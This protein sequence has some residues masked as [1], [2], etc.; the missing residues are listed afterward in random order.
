[1]GLHMHTICLTVTFSSSIDNTYTYYLW[2]K[3]CLGR[4]RSEIGRFHLYAMIEA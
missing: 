1:M 4:I 3:D 2:L